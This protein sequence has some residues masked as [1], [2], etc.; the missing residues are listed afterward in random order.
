M[1]IDDIYIYSPQASSISL[2]KQRL[3]K[4]FTFT[5]ED[6]DGTYLGMYIKR[7]N[8]QVKIHQA[9]YTRSIL[10]RYNFQLLPSVKTPSDP[11]Q[12]LVR[13]QDPISSDQKS[14]YLSKFRSANFLPTNTRPD[15]AY[16][17][18]LCGR[19]NL[20]PRDAHVAAIDR[21][22][23]YIAGTPTHSIVYK[24]HK[25]DLRGFIDAD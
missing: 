22:Y 11:T 6:E 5:E 16:H 19:F 23:A 10:H 24:A 13:E 3:S 14:G 12:K 2:F 18:S 21:A 17:L 7:T 9:G 15:L 4:T 25:T 8:D 1:H 20:N